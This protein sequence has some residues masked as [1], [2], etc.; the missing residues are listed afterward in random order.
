MFGKGSGR[1]HN[2]VQAIDVRPA[3]LQA[4][5]R[6]RRLLLLIASLAISASLLGGTASSALALPSNFFGF[7]AAGGQATSEPEMEAVARSGAKY[8]RFGLD[9]YSWYGHESTVWQ[10]WDRKFELAWQHGITA[11]PTLSSRCTQASIELPYEN[12]WGSWDS[13][14]KAVVGRYGYGGSFW[15]GK[16]NKREVENW[17]IQNEPNLAE[18]GIAGYANGYSYARFFQHT[19]EV[20]HAA[21]GS[22]FPTHAIWGGMMYGNVDTSGLKTQKPHDFM[23]AAATYPSV[24]PWIDGVAIHPYEWGTN[25]VW[26]T[27]DDINEARA[28]VNNFFG[29]G[30]PLWITEVG[31]PIEGHGDEKHP[32]VTLASQE[33]ALRVLFDWVKQEQ[34]GKNIQALIFYMYRDSNWNNSWDSIC[35]LRSEVLPPPADHWAQVTFRPAWFAFQDE[36]GVP[37]WPVPPSVETTTATNVSTTE[38]TLNGTVNPRGL[39]TGYHFEYGPGSSGGYTGW[40]PGSNPEVGWKEESV[41]KSNTL[42]GLQPNTT[43]HYRIVGVN[44]NH[45]V[46]G[47]QDRVFRTRSAVAAKKFATPAS[48]GTWTAGHPIEYADVSGD[49]KADAIGRTAG[50]DLQVGWS[51]GSSFLYATSWAN[52]PSGYSLDFGDTNGDGRADAIGRNAA[53]EVKV[54]WSSGTGFPGG[55]IWANWPTSFSIDFADTNADGKVDAVGKNAAG[56]IK[57]AWSNGSNGFPGGT[58]WATWPSGYSLDLADVNGDGKADAVGVNSAGTIKVGLSTSTPTGYVFATPITWA[59]WPSGYSLEFADA[60]ADGKADAIGKNAAG[61]A[62]VGLSTGSAFS[63]TTSW[64]TWPSNYSLDLADV[65][66]DKRADA[67]GRGPAGD[68]QVG[69]STT[70]SKFATPTTWSSAYSL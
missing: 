60:N 31:W 18:R 13:F 4:P 66:G 28:D 69:L 15:T 51:N 26:R 16:G 17:E 35:G 12:E 14:V 30:K 41:S 54:S 42:T 67:I 59:T 64:A 10:D 27:T 55:S 61:D 53:G 1:T 20:L 37:H 34:A 3:R 24:K 11:L 33:D 38:A 50:G 32:S 2:R 8:W 6:G 44:E 58:I 29:A 45:E 65:S 7:A 49:G 57:V 19:S 39:P 40:A 22:F 36:A 52:W 5:S 62:K 43:Y 23:Q 25:A 56:E 46:S 68:T 9:C 47:S 63:T 48:W 70:S 21:Q